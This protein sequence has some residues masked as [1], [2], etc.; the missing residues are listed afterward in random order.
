A[1]TLACLLLFG[2]PARRRGWRRMLGLL[3]L[4]VFCV[5]G[6]LSCGGSGG[7][8]GSSNPGTT[9]GAYTVT[10]TGSTSSVTESTTLTVTVN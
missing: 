7:G 8:G 2:L 10:V 9:P 6:V 5:G 1:T 3:A 4:A